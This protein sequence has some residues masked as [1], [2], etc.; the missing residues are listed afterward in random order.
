MRARPEKEDGSREIGADWACGGDEVG[1]EKYEDGTSRA[2]LAS[3][4]ARQR[5]AADH[6]GA[7][8]PNQY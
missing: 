5:R 8:I 4:A 1:G 7:A 3:P 6:Y 2:T